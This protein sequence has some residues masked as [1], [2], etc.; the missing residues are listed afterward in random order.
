[1]IHRHAYPSIIN[2]FHAQSPLLPH[3]LAKGE[4]VNE[5]REAYDVKMYDLPLPDEEV[6]RG[7]P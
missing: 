5:L 2:Q 3:R 6:S 7:L 1:M 4:N